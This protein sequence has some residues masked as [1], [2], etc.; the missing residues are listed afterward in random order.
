MQVGFE[1]IEAVHP[2]AWVPRGR[3]DH[4]SMRTTTMMGA[5]GKV[6]LGWVYE[7]VGAMVRIKKR[8]KL[9]KEKVMSGREKAARSETAGQVATVGGYGLVQDRGRHQGQARHGGR[10]RYKK[11]Q[12]ESKHWKTQQKQKKAVQHAGTT[13]K[14]VPRS[15]ENAGCN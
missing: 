9:G 8:K 12:E 13:D 14:N 11:I 1:E 6:Q 10:G 4:R 2:P 15:K 7:M 5:R 3:D